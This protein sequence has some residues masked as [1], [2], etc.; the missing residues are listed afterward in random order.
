[1]THPEGVVRVAA[2]GDLHC[3][4]ASAGMLQPLF[5]QAAAAADVLVLCGDLTDY[6]LAEEAQILVKELAIGA[7]VPTV[8]VLGNHDYESGQQAEV[9]KIL[10]DAGIVLLDGESCELGGVGFAGV[11]GFAGGFGRGTLGA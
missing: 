10:I 5:A 8:A 1:M 2:I 6:G 9:Q 3:S 4:K 7:K 11:K